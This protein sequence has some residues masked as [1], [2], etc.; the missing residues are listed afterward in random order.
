MT[1]PPLN[2]VRSL[3]FHEGCRQDGTRCVK[4]MWQRE[5]R[6][7]AGQEEARSKEK[8]H[9]STHGGGLCTN[10]SQSEKK[11]KE[12]FASPSQSHVGLRFAIGEVGFFSAVDWVPHA[13]PD[14]GKP[15]RMGRAVGKK[16]AP[17]LRTIETIEP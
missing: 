3:R 9:T 16:Y 15:N 4:G 17:V 6:R 8:G 14:E 11:R 5:E 7:R 13:L 12:C 1:A 10:E 2:G